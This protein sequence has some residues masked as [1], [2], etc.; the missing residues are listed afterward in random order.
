LSQGNGFNPG[1]AIDFDGSL[2]TPSAGRI[3]RFEDVPDILNMAVPCVDYLVPALGIAR[4]TITLWTGSDGE[5]KTF[6]AQAMAVAVAQGHQFLGMLCQQAPA[7]Y[8][9]P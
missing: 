6:L 3:R 1:V 2:I 5:G 4:N 7:L 9:D 8:I